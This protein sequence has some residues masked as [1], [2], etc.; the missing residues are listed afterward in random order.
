MTEGE[1]RRLPRHTRKRDILPEGEE[2]EEEEE[3]AADE[4]EIAADD[5]AIPA[6]DAD[7]DESADEDAAGAGAESFDLDVLARLR[8]A[9]EQPD[10][11]KA[12]TE[13]KLS[14]EDLFK[15]LTIPDVVPIEEDEE[16]GEPKKK[17]ASGRSRV[18]KRRPKRAADDFERFDRVRSLRDL[19]LTTR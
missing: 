4:V 17:K 12:E 1:P 6:E 3:V 11:E 14:L 8:G 18:A 2:E 5:E 7:V 16:A 15:N 10:E 9:D 19:D 13:E